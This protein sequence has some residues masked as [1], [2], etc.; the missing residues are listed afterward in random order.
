MKFQIYKLFL[1]DL[2]FKYLSPLI[3]LLQVIRE[4]IQSKIIA[5]TMSRSGRTG[6]KR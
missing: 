4:V 6:A 2:Q 5:T 3:I 1:T